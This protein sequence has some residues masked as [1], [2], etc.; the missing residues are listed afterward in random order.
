MGKRMVGQGCRRVDNGWLQGDW[1]V[2]CGVE[3]GG[4]RGFKVSFKGNP[5]S[6]SHL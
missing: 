2:G 4:G 6:F 3:L 1:L 5:H